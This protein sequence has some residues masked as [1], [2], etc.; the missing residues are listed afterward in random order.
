ME[1]VYIVEA[2]RT[3]IGRRNGSLSKIH[4]VDLFSKV[5]SAA[6]VKSGLEP[7]LVDH[8]IG[9]C[10]GQFGEQAVNISRNAWLSAGFPEEVVATTVDRQCGSSLQ[11][12]QFGFAEIASGVSDIVVAG[13]IESMSRI[14]MM[15]NITPQSMPVTESLKRRYALED[16]WF[17]QARGAQMIADKYNI[18]RERMDEMSFLSHVKAHKNSS[19]SMNEKVPILLDSEER[20]VTEDE[21]IRANASLEKMSALPPAFRGLDKITAGNSSQISDGASACIIASESA[22]KT[23]SLRKRAR[24]IAFSYAGVNPEIMLTGVIPATSRVLRKAGMK[25]DDVDIFEVNEAFASVPLAW[26]QETGVDEDRLN[27]F[28]GAIALGH[29]LGATGTRI[30]STMVNELEVTGKKRGLIAICEGGGM[31]NS[32]ILEKT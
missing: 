15:S 8:F 1:D 31:A 21:G 5:V 9:G 12:L 24:L 14:P 13:G 32:C 23:H 22:V 19:H 25:S 6:V 26:M 2:L 7:G 16:G 11:A 30:V 29:P 3:P 10:V 28:G 4:P 17:S 27:P 18:S 20:R